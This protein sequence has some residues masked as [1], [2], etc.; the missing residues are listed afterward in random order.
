[1]CGP[2]DIKGW[3]L[4]GQAA[5][6]FPQRRLRLESVVPA[7]EGQKANYVLWCPEEFPD[8]V[9]FSWDFHPVREPGLAMFWFCAR[10]RSGEDIFDPRLAPRAGQYEQ[11]H[12]GDINAFHASYF[13][14]GKPGGFHICNLRRS[15]GFQLVAQGGDPIPSFI[16]DS[17]YRIRVFKRGLEVQFAIDELTAWY[18]RDEGQHGPPLGAGKIGFRQMAPLVAEYANLEVHRLERT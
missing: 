3:R 10:G 11:Y 7:A 9:V 6:T 18:Y 12:H 14:R 13:R 8:D 5:I 17:P 4:E 16:Y 2:D 1:L 15:Y